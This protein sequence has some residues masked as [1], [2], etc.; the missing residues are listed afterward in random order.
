MEKKILIL[1][2]S[3]Y[4]GTVLINKI[5]KKKLKVI[6][7]DNHLFGKDIHNEE[8]I[9]NKD[10][11]YEFINSNISEIEKFDKK[12]ENVSDVVILAAI[13][14]DPLSKKYP[15]LTAKINEDYTI[16]CLNFLNKKDIDRV[17][18][19]ST[20]SNYGLIKD[21]EIAD[22]SFTLNPLSVYAKSK[23]N[24]ENYIQSKKNSFNF[25][26]VILRFATAFGL[27]PRMRFDLTVNEFTIDLLFKKTLEVYDAETWR[28]YF[29]TQDFAKIILQILD[30]DKELLKNEIF[31]VGVD[32]NNATKND[33]L[34]II[35]S[36]ADTRKVKI[37]D[38]GKDKR[39]YRVS[40]KKINQLIKL[41]DVMTIKD[42]VE[43]I[44]KEFNLGKFDNYVNAPHLYGNF[45]IKN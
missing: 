19:V 35:K 30:I 24:I 8:H 5:L 44:S 15:D 12:L 17:I 45:T 2:G 21:N 23:V 37:L 22:E 36:F 1:G 27:S 33:I 4:I 29:H 20:C 26:P 32:E 3:G 43:E 41:N 11:N 31:N 7:I 6:N 38:K 34:K 18:F 16:K 13:V 10:K 40:F 25:S 14:G 39:N 28:P 9:R 42:G